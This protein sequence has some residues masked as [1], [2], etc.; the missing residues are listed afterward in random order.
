[1]SGRLRS[2]HIPQ[3]KTQTVRLLMKQNKN[4]KRASSAHSG[5]SF[6]GASGSALLLCAAPD[7]G[8]GHNN[9]R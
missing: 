7:D 2:A 1:M 5:V 4:K 9:E 6:Q 8:C 3:D